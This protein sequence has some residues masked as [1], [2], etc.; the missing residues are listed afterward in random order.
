MAFRTYRQ[1]L[2]DSLNSLREKDWYAYFGST[3]VDRGMHYYDSNAVGPLTVRPGRV[4]AKVFGTQAY[5]TELRREGDQLVFGCTCPYG[6]RCK[7]EVALLYKLTEED[8]LTQLGEFDRAE[9]ERER[10]YLASLS[11]PEVEALVIRFAPD[12]FWAKQRF[13]KQAGRDAEA[14]WEAMETELDNL[15]R[16]EHHGGPQEFEEDLE[17]LLDNVNALHSTDT[18][19]TLGWYRNLYDGIDRKNDNGELYDYRYDGYFEGEIIWE[20]LL[21]WYKDTDPATALQIFQ[22]LEAREGAYNHIFIDGWFRPFVQTAIEQPYDNVLHYLTDTDQFEAATGKRQRVITELLL[23][24]LSPARRLALLNSGSLNEPDLQLRRLRLL[25]ELAEFEA[26]RIAAEKLISHLEAHYRDRRSWGLP[27]WEPVYRFFLEKLGEATGE[28]KDLAAHIERY[29]TLF[30]NEISLRNA[31]HW[32]PKARAKWEAVVAAKSPANYAEYLEKEGRYAEAH[33]VYAQHERRMSP[34]H[35]PAVR[36]FY[37]RYAAAIPELAEPVLKDLLGK[38]LEHADTKMYPQVVGTLQ[39]LQTVL[40]DH[41]FG[42]L[43]ESIRDTYHRRY[44]LLRTMK[45]AG[46]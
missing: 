42:L 17:S 21:D 35:S 18:T 37:Y 32:L 31:T 38:Q 22:F 46:L 27:Q 33:A 14:A 45:E 20:N 1:S 4:Y 29:V 15:L 40:P 39:A 7:H 8:T 2:A 13:V 11:R 12:S 36:D 10:A 28:Q 23:D 41:E 3:I 24:R 30:A 5:E 9:G 16:T 34:Y 43:V 44:S 6:G 26:L 19:R 25:H